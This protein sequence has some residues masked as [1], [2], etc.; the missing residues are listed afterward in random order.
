MEEL[1]LKGLKIWLKPA[2]CT[3]GLSETETGAAK[4]PLIQIYKGAGRVLYPAGTGKTA[5]ENKDIFTGSSPDGG[6]FL[7]YGSVR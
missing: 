1:S 3:Q 5:H 7:K 6:L 2:F 4:I